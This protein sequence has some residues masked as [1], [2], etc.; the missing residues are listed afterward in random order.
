ML[1]AISDQSQIAAARRSA[2]ARAR[3]LGFDEMR[4]GRVAICATE[5]AS[6]IL[7]HGVHGHFTVTRFADS[8]GRGL[9]MLAAD[10]GPGIGD[11]TRSLEDGYSTVGTP[12]TG[13]GAIRRQADIF[14]IYSRPGAGTIV[15]AR[16]LGEEG[17]AGAAPEGELGIV[18]VPYPGDG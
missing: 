7:K 1:I 14:D 10:K 12:G 9:E 6:N 11:V 16:I 13:L 8:T 5:M 17:A 15:M 4:I 2:E 18:L 3:D